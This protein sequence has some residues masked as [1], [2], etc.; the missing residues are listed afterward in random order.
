[1]MKEADYLKNRIIDMNQ[2][3]EIESVEARLDA[4]EHEAVIQCLKKERAGYEKRM[5]ELEAGE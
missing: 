2:L 4:T 5:K 3:I 1:M